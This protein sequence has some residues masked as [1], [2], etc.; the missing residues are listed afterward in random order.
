MLVALGFGLGAALWQA[1]QARQQA[2]E[3]RNQAER[4]TA[5]NTFV[6]SLIRQFDPRA[7]QVSKAADLALLNSIEQ[8]ID[9]SSKAALISCCSSASRS[10]M[11]IGRAASLPLRGVFTGGPSP[12]PR[13]LCRPTTLDC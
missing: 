8:R 3:A 2:E 1:D 4:A 9:G 7:S 11:P 10:A 12:R 6:L 5:L 13:R